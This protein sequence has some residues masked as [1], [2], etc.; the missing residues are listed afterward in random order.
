MTMSS[1]VKAKDEM[2]MDYRLLTPGVATPRLANTL[3]GQA[4]SDGEDLAATLIEKAAGAIVG[5][6][7]PR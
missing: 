5:E 6:I 1:M 2:R 3:E 4:Q 7:L